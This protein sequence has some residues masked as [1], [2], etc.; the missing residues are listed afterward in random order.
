ML[1]LA[2]GSVPLA[3]DDFAGDR[4]IGRADQDGLGDV[5][6]RIVGS[7]ASLEQLA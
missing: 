6:R 7:A 5:W 4:L 3:F 1:V 2:D